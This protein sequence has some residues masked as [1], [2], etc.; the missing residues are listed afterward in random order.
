M[1]PP[2]LPPKLYTGHG[3]KKSFRPARTE[4]GLQAIIVEVD[5]FKIDFRAGFGARPPI[6][7]SAQE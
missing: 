5:L 6:K 7:P 2:N 3:L 1:E 4:A